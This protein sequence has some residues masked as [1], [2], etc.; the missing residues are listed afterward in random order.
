MTVQT[1]VFTRMPY[2]EGQLIIA[3]ECIAPD[4][5]RAGLFTWV[6]RAEFIGHGSRSPHAPAMRVV[7]QAA[8]DYRT[9]G[10]FRFSK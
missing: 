3:C 7:I 8:N 6:Q 9:H 10:N 1:P 4:Y 2:T 5:W